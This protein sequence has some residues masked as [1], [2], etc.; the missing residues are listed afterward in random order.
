MAYIRLHR[1]RVAVFCVCTTI[2]W[3]LSPSTMAQAPAPPRAPTNVRILS[4]TD[5]TP[6]TVSITT[7]ASGAT[8]SGTITVTANAA[9]NFL[10]GLQ[11]KLD[12]ANLGAELPTAPYRLSW[13]TRTATG[14][15]HVLTAIARDAAGNTATSSPVTVSVT[16]TVASVTL[17]PDDTSLNLDATSH[18]SD[19][20]LT[21]Y[22]WPDNK[23]AN[24]I[25]MKFDLSGFAAGTV[26][27]QAT[28]NLSL[29][30]SDTAT[31]PT[32]TITAHKVLAKNPDPS[33]ATGYTSDGITPWTANACCSSNVPMA[34]ADISAAYDT[35]NIDK[36]AGYKA[37]DLTT[38]L[39]EWV[40]NPA[41]NFGVL[42]NSDTAKLR[43]HYRYFASSQNANVNQRPYLTVQ[44]APAGS[45]T[46]PPVIGNVT[47]S[48]ITGNAA[49]VAWTTNELSD[50]QV[51]FG[52]TTAYGSTTSLLASL[53]TVHAAAL[54]GLNPGT[55]YHY[56]VRSRDASGNAA[57]SGDFAF[58]TVVV[59]LTAPTVSLTAPANASTVSGT[60]T[61]SAT[62]ADNIGVV[63]VQFK[64]DGVSLGAEDTN[65]PFGL[66]WDTTTVANG[67][68]T[69]TAVARDAAGNQTTAATASVTVSN[70]VAAGW[71]HEPAGYAVMTDWAMNALTGSGWFINNSDGLATITTDGAAPTSPSNVGQW[72]YPAGYAG[73]S[74]PA[75]MAYSLPSTFTEGFVGVSWKPS[76]PWQGHSSN[77]NKIFFLLGGACGN[78]IP[79]MYG[80]PGGPYQLRVAPEWG[81]WSWLTPNVNDVPVA[82]G[83]W[84][85][86]ELYFKYNTSGANGIVRWWM[87]GTLIGEYTT[88]SFPARGC[89]AEFQ[90]SPTWGGVG[91]TKSQ[92]DY[93]WFDHAHISYPSGS[94]SSDTVPPNVALSAPSGGATVSGATVAVSATA[95]DNVGIAGVQ[96]KLDGANLGAEDT[97]A[98][99]SVSWD[100]TKVANGSHT[101]TAVAR[102]AAGN[103]TTSAAVSVTVSNST[104]G[105][106]PTGV[107]LFQ[108][109]FD[110][111][112]VASRGWYDNT[113]VLLS[114]AEHVAGSN[115]SIQ[116]TFNAGATSP[117]AGSALRRKFTPTNSVYLSYYVKYSANWVGSQKPYHPHEFH[118]L[119]TL[120]GDWSGL[121]FDHLTTYI[122]QNG[123]TP[124]IGIQDGANVDQSRIG[125]NLVALTE[126]RGVAGCNGSSDAY[127][128]NCYSNGSQF[129]NEKKWFAPAQY[130]SDT[131]GA[132]YKNN[133]H[134]VEAYIKLNSISAGKGVN[135]GIVQYW[136]DG[137]LIIDRRDVLLRTGANPTLQFNQLIIAPYI[138]DGSPV[139]QTMWIDNLAVGTGK[140]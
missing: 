48:N 58:T 70:T 13:D 47:S 20:Q 88:V 120:D 61:V 53:V 78:L 130:F 98:P 131:P 28:L 140:P 4:F 24:V 19:P 37:W 51:D 42:L 94:A 135:D 9:D 59:D 107:L 40:S 76:N 128:D 65:S 104:G 118:F 126:N 2:L 18:S 22:T 75:T 45:D 16:N 80:P 11:F 92:T 26:I 93:F 85:R 5:T 27:R 71:P 112:S 121:S 33:A 31:E 50:S 17:T 111:T 81:N 122:E 7:P 96:L 127:P 115:A 21:T 38:L 66:S 119:T 55:V 138:G 67:S 77:V 56:R 100:T 46:N 105:G 125:V 41:T 74:A 136:Y 110:D 101:L 10:I 3:S 49:T 63:G 69:I 99:Y 102:D 79:I 23:V 57:T 68:H 32:Y 139:T 54:V 6:P 29:L 117:T 86:I 109:A 72:K 134:L 35:Q 43:D 108:E 123:G 30:S 60:V 124:L 12:G 91:G 89:F 137:Q 95:S 87:D 8:V 62:A 83:A 97:T 25:L 132:T 52:T 14:G 114:T 34:Q 84:H 15:T 64:R 106:P 82:L 44:F 36:T 129:V 103:T 116:Y 133:W 1:D 73:G 113:S 90:F 39:Q